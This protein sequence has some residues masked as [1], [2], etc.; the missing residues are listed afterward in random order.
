MGLIGKLALGLSSGAS[1]ALV[2]ETLS[3]SGVKL[4]LFDE[5][6]DDDFDVGVF[7]AFGDGVLAAFGD[8]V[9]AA[10]GDGD[11]DDDDDG[12]AFDFSRASWSRLSR[13][14]D[15]TST[16]LRI[17]SVTMAIASLLVGGFGW[18]EV[19]ARSCVTPR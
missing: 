4:T 2:E 6:F 9:F 13:N 12:T 1:L 3:D 5:R 10:F 7:A 14:T 17:A 8:F 11:G 16:S 18:E 15:I 19:S